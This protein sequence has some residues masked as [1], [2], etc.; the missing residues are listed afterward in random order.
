MKPIPAVIVSVFCIGIV[1]LSPI[2]VQGYSPWFIATPP[3]IE[4]AYD[5]DPLLQSGY[6][7]KGVTVAIVGESIGPTFYSDVKTFSGK[8]GLPDPVISVVQPYGAS[9]GSWSWDEITADTELAHAMAPNAKILLVLVGSDTFLDGFSYVIDH[10][11]A[12]I[13]TMSFRNTLSAPWGLGTVEE[14]NKEYAWSVSEKIT[15]IHPSGDGGSNNTVP[16]GTG[17]F[18]TGRDSYW[19]PNYSPYVTAVGGTSF[20]RQCCTGPP[21]FE[22]GWERSGGGPS[23]LFPEPAWQTGLGVP[24]NGFR[25]IPDIALDASCD[26]PYAFDYDNDQ[27]TWFCGTSVGAPTFAGI[28]A[29]I[30]QAAGGRVGF[31]NPTLY[32]LAA[33]DP[34]VYHEITS[35]CSLVQVGSST[36]TGYCAH[37]GWNFVTGWGSIDAAKLA[38]HLA[39]NAQILTTTST[40]VSTSVLM[41]S[42]MSTSSAT[43]ATYTTAPSL[44]TLALQNPVLSWSGTLIL[45]IAVVIVAVLGVIPALRK[46]GTKP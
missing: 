6:T 44:S 8:Y 41:T 37:P 17:V 29:D 35:G 11:A 3:Y 14:Y 19:M 7:G 42:V 39:P 40:T 31:L 18:V 4:A 30:D 38:K 20:A 22:E 46:R 5:V 25:N 33:S 36:E 1:L 26:T 28:V 24:Q 32:A 9:G 13:A 23:N 2:R 16:W 43:A 34:S 15:L 10:N 27:E 21:T 12:D 45:G